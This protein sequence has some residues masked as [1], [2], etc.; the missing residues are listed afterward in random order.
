[1]GDGI[2]WFIRAWRRLDATLASVFG[3]LKRLLRT[4]NV[5]RFLVF[6]LILIVLAVAV[7]VV[8]FP[9]W[10]PYVLA[11]VVLLFTIP[12]VVLFLLLSLPFRAKSLVKLIRTGYPE[13]MQ[14]LVIRVAARKLHEESIET[15]RL[16]VET[17]WLESRKVLRR[18]RKRVDRL[19]RQLDEMP[20]D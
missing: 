17:A 3:S 5:L 13:N 1:M 20:D 16:L 14:E 4:L 2:R 7:L 8:I 11:G 15:E 18:Y 10:T 19:K 9:E 12:L 6:F